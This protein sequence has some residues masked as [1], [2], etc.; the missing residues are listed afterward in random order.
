MSEHKDEQPLSGPGQV[1][2]QGRTTLGMSREQAADVLNLPLRV[3]RAIEEND[4]SKLPDRVYVNGYV[5]SYA[6]LLDLAAQ[7]LIDAWWAQHAEQQ[8]E[9]PVEALTETSSSAAAAASPFKMGRWVIIALVLSAGFVYFVTTNREDAG[10]AKAAVVGVAAAPQAP[11]PISS[12]GSASEVLVE[13]SVPMSARF[14]TAPQEQAAQTPAAEK[15]DRVGSEVAL[16]A[17]ED[18]QEP[19][20][21]ANTEAAASE[22]LAAQSAALEEAA[23]T[24]EV[25]EG[26][27]VN[28]EATTITAATDT[29]QGNNLEDVAAAVPEKEAAKAFA[30]PRLTEF[31]NNTIDLAFAADCWF[32]IRNLQSELLYAD[33]GRAGQSRQYIGDGPFALKLGFSSGVSLSYNDAAIDLT[34]YTRRNIA[35][36]ALGGEASADRGEVG[37]SSPQRDEQIDGEAQT[38]APADAVQ[39]ETVPELQQPQS[40]EEASLW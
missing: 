14:S 2:V 10:E 9:V 32:E 6:K 12:S 30:L 34:Q 18:A 35:N 15:A 27:A 22:S 19:P 40:A 26:Q 4:A 16:L 25:V 13:Q 7:P 37:L 24:V 20:Q 28:A 8:T 5:R 23:N 33:L 36:V 3:V 1:L 31:G 39:I 38:Q 11:P 29:D 17:N 21:S